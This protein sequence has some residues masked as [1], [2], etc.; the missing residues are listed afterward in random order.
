MAWSL[1]IVEL[2]PFECHKPDSTRCFEYVRNDAQRFGLYQLVLV[3]INLA[4]GGIVLTE[5]CGRGKTVKN[6]TKVLKNQRNL[7]WCERKKC[8][9]RKTLKNYALDAKIGVDTTV[10]EPPKV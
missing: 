9:A 6:G 2:I 3:C 4:F 5:F 8:K 1:E 10:N 7:E